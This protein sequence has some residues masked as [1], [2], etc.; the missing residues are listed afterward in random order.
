MRL[1]MAAMHV[2]VWA[3]SI[4]VLATLAGQFRRQVPV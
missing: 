4:G 3:I 2:T 1:T